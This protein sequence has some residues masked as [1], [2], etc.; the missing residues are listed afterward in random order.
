MR[1]SAKTLAS[2]LTAGAVVLGVTACD[3]NDS[4][5]D[6]GTSGGSQT[7]YW[8][9]H[10]SASDPFWI[11]AAKGAT[12]A[13]KDLGVSVK[14]SFHDGDVAAEK[15]AI[16]AAIAADADGI[17]VSSPKDGALVDDVQKAKDAGIPVVFFNTDD[18]T[19]GRDA[20]V[21]ADLEGV[22]VQWAQYLVDN[23][24]VQSGDNVWMPVEVPGATYQ[25]E[26]E[27]GIK[28]VLDPIGVTAEVFNASS[29]PA[30][31]LANMTDYLTANADKV[32]A[33]I[34][35]GDLVMGN[36]EKAFTTANISAGDVPVVGWGNTNDT[37]QAVKDGYVN[38][39]TWQFPD[40]QGYLPIALL[41]QATDGFAIG[42]DVPTQSLYEE[43]DAQKFIDLTASK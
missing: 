7:F 30:Q 37:A 10:G 41:K 19:T 23:D 24:L 31:S 8:I 21:G 11:G 14:E 16:Q 4:S 17:A 29:D 3:S 40:A 38:A 20:Y 22:G 2:L 32:D 33:V 6:S 36:I 42:F 1:R 43:S 34:G 28:S 35:M 18:K 5:N 15:E 13:G 25:T 26:E 9:N 27:K 39:A 12:Q